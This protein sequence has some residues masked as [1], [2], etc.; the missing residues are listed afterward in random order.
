M[1]TIACV[2]VGTKYPAYYV[3]RLAR[4][5]AETT[6]VPYRFVCFTDT[7]VRGVECVDLLGVGLQSWWAKMVLF[8]PNM[9][10]DDYTIYIDLDMVLLNDGLTLLS[11][12]PVDFGICKNFHYLRGNYGW[13]KYGSCVMTFRPGWGEFVWNVFDS[14]RKKWMKK[15]S[16]TGDQH[17]IQNVLEAKTEF[18][19]PIKFGL[20]QDYVPP[21]Y[22]LH[23]KDFANEPPTNTCVA[24][25]GGRNTPENS[26][27]SWV[28]K[29]W[30]GAGK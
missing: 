17:F 8:H 25:F 10:G 22:F 14:D 1:I 12:L 23:Y 2:N 13:C 21:D 15:Y 5:V 29:R 6:Q 9:R 26:P 24:V 11:E 19:T 20:L 7:P 16:G 18:G 28:R 30:L 4:M 3:Q 27:Y